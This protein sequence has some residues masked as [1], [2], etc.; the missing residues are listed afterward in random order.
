MPE[1]VH[2]NGMGGASKGEEDLTRDKRMLY[3]NLQVVLK[4]SSKRATI[5]YLCYLPIVTIHIAA[6]QLLKENIS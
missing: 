4:N 6:K 1:H 5:L 3:I 2:T